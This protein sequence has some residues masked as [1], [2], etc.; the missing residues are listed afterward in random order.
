M[1]INKDQFMRGIIS[2][3]DNEMLPHSEGNYRVILRMAKTAILIK[4]DGVFNTIKN[5]SLVSMFGVIDENDRID[6]DTLAR[7]LAGGIDKDEFII[8]FKI[9]GVD[10]S[11][12]FTANDIETAKNYIERS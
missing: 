4:P 12:G 6:I 2:F 7:V 5:N 9:L 1:M 8:K 11:L 10:Y 3:I